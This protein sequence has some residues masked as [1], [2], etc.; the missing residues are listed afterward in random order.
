MKRIQGQLVRAKVIGAAI[1]MTLL[2]WPGLTHGYGLTGVGGSL[3]YANPEDLDGT[4]ALGVHAVL[5]QQG[6]RVHLDPNMHYWHVNGVSDVSPNMDLTYHFRPEDRWTPYL[7]GGVGMNFVHNRRIERDKS[8]LG[9]NAI[10]GLRFPASAGKYFLEG[11]YTASELSQVSLA[12]GI[13][14]HAR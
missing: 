3:G 1:T 2:A 4:T 8:D 13:T 5:E 7:G 14:F 10:A 6:T 9:V 12:T 11:R